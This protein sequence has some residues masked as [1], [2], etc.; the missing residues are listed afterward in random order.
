MACPSGDVA[1]GESP[2]SCLRVVKFRRTPEAGTAHNQDLSASE[3]RRRVFDPS[4]RHAA[5][6]GPGPRGRV[7]QLGGSVAAGTTHD[8]YLPAG[9]QRCRMQMPRDVQAASDSPA[10]RRRVVQLGGP[11]QDLLIDINA[12]ATS[13]SPPG[14]KVAVGPTRA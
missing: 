13:T 6:E 10:P 14:S 11:P 2:C 4:S 9:E 1:V 8:E 12:P 3:Q 7:V 5:G